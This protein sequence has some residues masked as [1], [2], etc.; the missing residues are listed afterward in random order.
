[1][2]FERV[3]RVPKVNDDPLGYDY[4]GTFHVCAWLSV[5]PYEL[6]ELIRLGLPLDDFRH[7]VL[8]RTFQ[9]KAVLNWKSGNRDLIAD[10]CRSAA[11]CKGRE[12]A[13]QRAKAAAKRSRASKRGWQKRRGEP[14]GRQPIP[15]RLRFEVLERC[16]F[17]CRYCGRKSP[18]VSLEIDHVIPIADGGTNDPANLVAACWECNLGKRDRRL[19]E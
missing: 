17:A 3:G 13:A 15:L 18:D 4:A 14:I 16:G 7:P 9:R 11:E 8:R 2:A 10:A 6:N 1:M 19:S 12:I 5:S